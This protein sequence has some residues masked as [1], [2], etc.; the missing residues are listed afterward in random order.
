MAKMLLL[1]VG[2]LVNSL[3][4]TTF[5]ALTSKILSNFSLVPDSCKGLKVCLQKTFSDSLTVIWDT[6][7]RHDDENGHQSSSGYFEAKRTGKN[8]V[9]GAHEFFRSCL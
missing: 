3:L 2:K 1:F 8:N 6:M 7:L 4:L 5:T 9:Q